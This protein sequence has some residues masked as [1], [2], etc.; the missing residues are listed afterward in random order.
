MLTLYDG[1]LITVLA[2]ASDIRDHNIHA[3]PIGIKV[4][5]RLPPTPPDWWSARRDQDR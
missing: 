1:T 5:D 3:V 2:F 4:D